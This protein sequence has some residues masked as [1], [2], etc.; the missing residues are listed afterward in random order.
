MHDVPMS[1]KAKHRMQGLGE[2]TRS[3]Y[4]SSMGSEQV[5]KIPTKMLARLTN[6]KRVPQPSAGL[7]KT[8][9]LATTDLSEL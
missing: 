4:S 1:K 9:R 8:M 2:T 5:V 3:G 6:R 7:I